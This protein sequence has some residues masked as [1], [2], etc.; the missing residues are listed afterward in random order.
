IA[1]P[2]LG[3]TTILMRLMEQ[4]R[5]TAHTAF[6]FQTHANFVEF[7]RNLL[8]DLQIE[9]CGHDLDDLQRQLGDVLIQGTKE[10]KRIVVAIDE[11]QNLDAAT[12]E[13]VRVLSNFEAPQEKLLQIIL[14]GQPGLADKLASPELE[15]LRQRVSIVTHFPPLDA[16]DI[17]H[18]IAHRL[19]A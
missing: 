4:L 15:Q 19:R 16:E 18:Y 6:L 2:G 14:A 5:G 17:P 9:P 7:L 8:S 1:A 3:K 13:M 10:G 12:L 11:A